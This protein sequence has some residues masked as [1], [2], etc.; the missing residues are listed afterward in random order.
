[1]NKKVWFMQMERNK[2]GSNYILTIWIKMILPVIISCY[3]GE[4]INDKHWNYSLPNHCD[5]D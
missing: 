5:I 2:V 3:R 4:V 1:M